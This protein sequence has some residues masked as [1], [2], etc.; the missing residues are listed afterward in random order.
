MNKI[1]LGDNLAELKKISDAEF[2]LIYIDPPFNTGRS[3]QRERV[4]TTADIDGSRTGFQGKK[5]KTE[6]VSTISY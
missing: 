2:H 6:V 4:K 1:I 3:Q 5:Y